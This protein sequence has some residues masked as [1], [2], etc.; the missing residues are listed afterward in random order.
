MPFCLVRRELFGSKQLVDSTGCPQLTVMISMSLT[1]TGNK[2]NQAQDS[3][4]KASDHH[5]RIFEA[6]AIQSR[7]ELSRG[8]MILF[9]LICGGDYDNGRVSCHQLIMY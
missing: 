2:N 9:A 8:G 5:V 4:G 1:L 7:R 6:D 3:T